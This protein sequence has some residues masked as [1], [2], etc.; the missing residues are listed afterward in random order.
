MSDLSTEA[1]RGD[2]K[3]SVIPM[4]DL[5][6]GGN[7]R[8][9]L[10][11]LVV[12]DDEAVLRFHQ[13]T[14]EN[15]GYAVKATMS[16]KQATA[17]LSREIFD[18]MVSDIHIPDL[19][20]ISLLR[21]I[22]QRD[23]DLPVV[24]I[25]GSATVSTAVDAIEHGVFKYLQ[26]PVGTKQLLR[27]VEQACRMRRMAALKREALRHRGME[28]AR[29]WD[30][31]LMEGS[32]Q[33]ALKSLWVAFQPVVRWPDRSIFAYEAL[34]RTDEETVPHPGAFLSLAE[35]LQ[36]LPELGRALRTAVVSTDLSLVGDAKIFVNLHPID[37]EDPVLYE[38]GTP[39]SR[40]A[41][42]IVLEVTERA[43]LEGVKDVRSRIEILKRMGFKIALDDLGAGYAG[44]SSFSVLEP[45]VVKIDMSLVRGVD[46]DPVKRRLI[47][48]MAGLCGEMGIEVIVEGVESEAER[49]TLAGIGCFLQ[50]GFLF[51][52]P[53]HP[54]PD[55]QW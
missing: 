31:A 37:L 25:T 38:P 4:S 39:F 50:Q 18:A 26:K 43:A 16:G 15:A 14:L 20:G 6:G 19:D 9:P 54:F 52:R 12:D 51:A 49:E 11:V 21:E 13:R 3:V 24:L 33:R 8:S 45:D 23:V 28:G 47:H 30:L 22:G 17:L 48:S 42:R 41:D 40:V 44:L 55:V 35:R 5:A 53:G 32:F 27:V 36:R 1:Q 46:A 29:I 7:G 34:L 2:P 10:K